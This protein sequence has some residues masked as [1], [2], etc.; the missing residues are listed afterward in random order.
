MTKQKLMRQLAIKNG[1][2]NVIHDNKLQ[3]KGL[4]RSKKAEN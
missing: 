3:T 1:R 2:K 4:Q